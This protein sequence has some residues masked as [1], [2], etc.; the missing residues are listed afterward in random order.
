MK[1]DMVV[2]GITLEPTGGSDSPN[3]VQFYTLGTV[4]TS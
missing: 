3:P 1:K 4:S 2:L